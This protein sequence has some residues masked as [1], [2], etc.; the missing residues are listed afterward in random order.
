MQ[1]ALAAEVARVKGLE[2]VELAAARGPAGAFRVGAILRG[3]GDLGVVEPDGRHV[4]VEG[5]LASEGHLELENEELSGAGE[6]VC[7]V[8]SVCVVAKKRRCAYDKRPL[9]DE[10]NPHPPSSQLLLDKMMTSVLSSIIASA[11][12]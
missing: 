1:R 8:M 11:R 6:A 7:V 3:E 12:V 5:R 9:Q 10:C 4:T 2:Q